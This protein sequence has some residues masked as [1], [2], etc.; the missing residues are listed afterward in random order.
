ML[1][2]CGVGM[3]GVAYLLARRGWRV[4]GCDERPGSLASWLRAAGV[5]VGEGHD[6]AH[7]DADGG[8]GRVIVTPAVAADEPELAAARARG[9]PVFRRGEVLAE[10]VAASRGVAVCGAHGKTTTSCFTTRLLQELGERPG[11]C[12]GG[13]TATL[14][15]VAG[16]GGG[17]LLVAEADESDGTLALYRP[18][19]TVLTNIDLDHLEHFGGEA[20]LADCFRRAVVQTREG[21]AV[22][23]DNRR[24]LEV[25]R[26]YRAPPLTY[27]FGRESRLRATRVRVGPASVAFDLAFDGV[28]AGRVR[29]GVSGRH[30]VL[31]ALGAAAAAL[32]LGHGLEAVAAA[33]PAACGELPGRRF[34]RVAA[35]GGI[36]CVAD[37]AHHPTELEAAVAMARAQRPGRL[38]VVFQPHRY[39]RTL[40]LGP[41][42]PAAFAGADEVV[43]L[44]VYAASEAPIEGGGSE[45]LYA[46]FR[47]GGWPAGRVKLARSAGEA[48]ASLR[49]TL[50]DGD[51][52][53]VAG[54]GDVIGLADRFR[55][56]CA[57]GWP[58]RRDPEGFE[59]QLLR[60]SGL[61]VMPN[62]PL[63]GWSS[64]GVGGVARWRVE[65]ER[66]EALA[67]VWR[68]CLERGVPWRFVGAGANTWFSDLG[69]PGCVARWAD[70]A[71]R[72]WLAD[73]EAVEVG[74]GWRGPA[75]LEALTR[76][77]LSGLE[78]LEG[79]PG[80]LGGWLAMNAGAQGEEIGSRVEWIRCLNPDGN[81]TIL[82]PHDLG[83]AY[84]ACR[85]L[86]GRVAVSCR[87][88][89][90]RAEMESIRAAR[91]AFRERRIPL[92]GLRTAGSVFRNP[93]GAAAG[94]LLD[95]AGCKGLRVGGAVVA[96]FHA[97]V[98]VAEAGAS[99]SDVLA[100]T[101]LMR[102][103]VS[104]ASGVELK[105]EICGLEEAETDGTE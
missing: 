63:A 81:M 13:T 64:L 82:S 56:A 31:N 87:L 50:R 77:G 3:A 48:W 69:E 62:G 6:P 100:L 54:A 23:G 104:R 99:A 79:V 7:L 60:V 18:A 86:E 95:A 22:C 80:S 24:A 94:R 73:G 15:G 1:G 42:F 34:E 78:F 59:A 96:A 70:G 105:P 102:A 49:Q 52:L 71:C 83:F 28:S 51:L 91:A 17:E 67:A 61:R 2:V 44:P 92:A 26:A 36:R 11:W 90:R 14:G 32:L 8:V 66:P 37:Y 68:L 39:T 10:L 29:L 72:D 47:A 58:A 43:L 25:A 65:A 93:P 27:G 57:D 19:V 89:L 9:L 30:N 35:A 40:A 76:E 33:L 85:G 21:V 5:A 55:A 84:R 88:M 97:N 45:D 46:H 98:A 103:R 20:A 4:S 75:L 101:L 41:A 74:C 38:I 16:C 12:I 53:L